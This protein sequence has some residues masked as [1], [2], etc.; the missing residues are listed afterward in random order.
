[1]VN[2]ILIFIFSL[3]LYCF[4]PAVYSYS[5]CL[6]LFIF[7]LITSIWFLRN[8]FDGNYFNFHFLFLFSFFFV[9]FVYPIFLYPHNK[10]YFSVYKL[11]FD[12]S[13]ITKATALAL[14]GIS[15]YFLG[16]TLVKNKST[17]YDKKIDIQ[18]PKSIILILTIL[19]FFFFILVLINSWRGIILGEFGSTGKENQ[20]LLALFQISFETALILEMYVSREKYNGK[21]KYFILNFNKALL[22]IGILFAFLFIR[23]GDR[24]P[25]IQLFLIFLTL[26]SIFVTRIS[27]KKFLI[28]VFSGML[29]L[30][31]ISYARTR[32]VEVLH[33][34]NSMSD[35][36]ERGEKRMNLN[37]FFDLGMDLIV[38]NRNLYVG[39]KYAN[40]HGLSYGKNMV[41]YIFAAI[42]RLPVIMT[43]LLFNK[44][45]TELSSGYIITKESL[46][47][48][49]TYGL[50]TN[51]IADLYMNFG[52][53]GVIVFMVFLGYFV[54]K[55][56]NYSRK[57]NGI[58]Y[59]LTYLLMI[60][61]SIYLPRAPIFTPLRF[62]LWSVILY[63][64]TKTIV[65]LII[66]KQIY[67]KNHIITNGH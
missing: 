26:Y 54:R 25:V 45:P 2:A 20:Y 41:H 29:I 62:I 34:K 21:L 10:N 47:P 31:F 3:I 50:G 64:M 33:R 53:L 11:N 12:E 46:G 15:S 57:K 67:N 6:I 49:A 19:S 24:G 28:I 61:F 32:N 56:Q 42:P 9:N 27:F 35:F 16:A 13:I 1:M 63:L 39:M 44:T 43:K 55:V 18:L 17:S 4:A 22:F 40:D 14:L 23:V 51:I 37:S 65:R 7:F 60:S 58:L 59:L 48:K 38:T 36:I 52:S 8:T 66:L 5:Y 30:T